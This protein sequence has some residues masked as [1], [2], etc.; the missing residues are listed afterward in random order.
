MAI[1]G[2]KILINFLKSWLIS[3]SFWELVSQLTF[4]SYDGMSYGESY[5]DW[6]FPEY[7]HTWY[8]TN[9]WCTWCIS[10]ENRFRFGLFSH[11]LIELFSQ[12]SRVSDG[13]NKKV[14]NQR[15]IIIIGATVVA[16]AFYLLEVFLQ[17]S[18]IY[19]HWS[20]KIPSRDPQWI[21]HSPLDPRADQYHGLQKTFWFWHHEKAHSFPYFFFKWY[22]ISK[23]GLLF[24]SKFWP[25]KT[26]E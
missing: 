14:Y 11:W 1:R 25:K 5:V 23:E 26:S 8:Y 10:D 17:F 19:R 21:I 15:T 13:V 4:V 3:F 16:I 12:Y 22:F 24:S 2:V 20:Q 7:Y 6:T 18:V 9:T